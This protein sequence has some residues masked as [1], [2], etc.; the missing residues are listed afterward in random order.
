MHDILLWEKDV[1]FYNEAYGQPAP[2]L[3]PVLLGSTDSKRRGCIIVC[4]GGGYGARMD[5]EG[6]PIA[7]RF[8]DAG[9]H[10]FVL[11]YRVA[12]YGG[13]AYMADVNRAVRLIRYR[14]DEF[15][16]DPEKIC[17]IGFS[18][19]GHL[20]CAGATHF[21]D[22]LE[23]SDAI[24]K[25]SS[26]PNAAILSYGVNSLMPGITHKDTRDRFVSY[27]KD[28]EKT[29]FDFSGENSVSDAT[30]PM[31]IWHTAGDT[32]VPVENALVMA[33]ALSAKKIP[34]ELHVFPEGDH[35]DGL[36]GNVACAREWFRLAADWLV[37]L[38]F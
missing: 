34:F 38:G 37:R 2:S 29:A 4:P 6:V 3:T 25:C 24:D 11:N 31:L 8:N 16:I 17:L 36:F 26:R 33:S 28:P 20:A 12:P 15:G 22:G 35:G 7:R 18:A 19:G 1:P 30:P 9:L 32:A 27:S 14:A 21:D 23:T 13:D 5:Y 10:A